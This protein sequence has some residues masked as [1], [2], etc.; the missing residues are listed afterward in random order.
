MD[1]KWILNKITTQ[2]D[3]LIQTQQ[4]T[5]ECLERQTT[6]L[7]KNVQ[8]LKILEMAEQ[9]HTQT[10]CASLKAQLDVLTHQPCCLRIS[11]DVSN[12]V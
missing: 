7:G 1:Q 2:L 4:A 10:E 9:Q 12:G 3:K 8:S 6:A 11:S 5:N